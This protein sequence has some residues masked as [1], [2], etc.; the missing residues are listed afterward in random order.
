[1][2]VSGVKSAASR[3]T[4]AA[5]AWAPRHPVQLLLAA[6]AASVVLSCYP[7]VFFGRSFVS[8]N[9]HSHTY[10]LYGEM[11]TV[12]GYKDVATDDEKG[13]DL[14]AAMW[15]SWPTSVVQ[16]RAL[17][18]HFE[19][20]LW[21]RY[22]SGGLPLL[23][24]GQ[25]MFGDP[26][27]FL[28]LLANGAAGWWDLK[29]LLAK[30][31]FAASLGFCALQLTKHLPAA[32]IIALS[33]PFLG[34]FAF[35]YSHPAFFSMCYAPFILLC[36]FKFM[37]APKGRRSALW[38]GM[39]VLANWM[40]INSGT[41]KEAYILLLGMNLGGC[42][43][44][45]FAQ[46]VE[47][48]IAKLGQALF[49]QLLS[50]LIATPI[51]LTFLITLRNSWTVYDAGGAFQL[52]PSLFVGLFDDIFY[53]QFNTGEQ[54]FVPSANF[55]ILAGVLWFCFGG[56]GTDPSKF[57]RGLVVT[58]LVALAFAFGIIPPSLIVRLP[59][60][61]KIYHIDNTFSCVA[62]VC[63]VLL[64]AFGIKSFWNDALAGSFRS[65]Y[66]RVM[67][68][69]AGLLALYLGT[70]E[71]AQ[72]SS[73]AFLQ[74]GSHIPKSSFF[75]GYAVLLV[76]A[77]VALPWIGRS[78]IKGNRARKWQALALGSM[79]VILH[80]RHGMHLETR[81]DAYVM[82]PQ[83]RVNLI[84]DASPT[85]GLLRDAR[86]EPSR[87]AGLD[88][89]LAPGYGGAIDVEMIDSADPL[90]NKHYKELMHSY[91]A[92]LIF[93]S[94]NSGFINDQLESD[95]PL[96]DMLNVRSYLGH[97][98]T[99]ADIIPSIKK[100]GSLDLNVYESSKVWPRAF[101]TDRLI[102]YGSETG[103]VKLLREGDGRPFV[104][105]P[106]T[107]LDQRT[108]VAG[109]SAKLPET[110]ARQVVPASDYVLTNNKTSFKIAAPAEG[111]V[112]LTEPYVAGDF[113]LRVNGD[114][115]SYFRVNSAFRG[116]YLPKAGEYHFS[117]AYWPR[118]LTVSLWI[119]GFGIILLLLWLGSIAGRP[120]LFA[121]ARA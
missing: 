20:P 12:P 51:W 93:A 27:H 112:V 76:I 114:P 47:G 26:V 108:E 46:S 37:D 22:N 74:V 83:P 100:I 67:G 17:F 120:R 96:F 109:L 10:L 87:S 41:V 105:V 85:L 16:S 111:V 1:L 81:F 8:P 48:K 91:G 60:L 69:L 40:I 34:F 2:L 107:E 103:F 59:F 63:L 45:L 78:V 6:A 43:T 86:A 52:Q 104:A 49:A 30:F 62:I 80:G 72:R 84:A 9:N 42:L 97:A 115:A 121:H 24:Q 89:H 68:S 66:L 38:L 90:L 53:R 36:W 28:V 113:Q 118:H 7:I 33:S 56:S 101:F 95:L 98:G 117:F 25:S 73:S 82:N 21:N 23:G 29:Y 31:L 64:A 5:A 54:H 88:Y 106:Q 61:G 18:K 65:S 79:F 71:A 57:A 4:S 102:P 44:L 19:L 77:L 110:T 11:P 13:S 3:L 14:G 35:R 55:L 15:Y 116:V 39:M 94:S 32:V 50:V 70:T 99:G 119:A 58:C 92:K 75:W